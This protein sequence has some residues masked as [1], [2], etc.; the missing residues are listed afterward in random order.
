M[1]YEYWQA[2]CDTDEEA[3]TKYE[4]DVSRAEFEQADLGV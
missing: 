3:Q 4:L 1:P 2:M